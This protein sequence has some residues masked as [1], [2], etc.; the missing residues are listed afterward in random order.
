MY[1]RSGYGIPP[2]RCQP[3]RPG[4]HD[5]TVDH[6]FASLR[7]GSSRTARTER[8]LNALTASD[9]PLRSGIDQCRAS[10]RRYGLNLRRAR[11]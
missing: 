3:R 7:H 4:T 5:H 2:T 1:A 11:R 10:S 8:Q 6:R 9:R